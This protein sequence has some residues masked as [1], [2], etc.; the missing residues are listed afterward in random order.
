MECFLSREQFEATYAEALKNF[1]WNGVRYVAVN[2]SDI[3]NEKLIN[4]FWRV[5]QKSRQT[6][7]VI[8]LKSTGDDC[9]M[10]FASGYECCLKECAAALQQH[11]LPFEIE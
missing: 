3:N 11:G 4:V 7:P 10:V 1:T 6:K 2:E 8:T 5:W 9:S